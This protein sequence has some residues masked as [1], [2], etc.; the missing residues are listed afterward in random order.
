MSLRFRCWIIRL[1][2]CGLPWLVGCSAL[3]LGYNQGP[4]MAYWWLDA[5]ADFSSEQRP[6]VKSAIEAWLA[7]QRATQMPLYARELATLQTLAPKDISAAQACA[8]IVPW[9]RHAERAFDQ[10]VPA[11][12]DLVPE[13]GAEQLAH[14]EQHYAEKNAELLHS[15]LQTGT[16]ERHKATLDRTVKRAESLYGRLEDAQRRL[17]GEALRASPFDAERWFAE[18]RQRQN[19][20]LRRLRQ[21]QRERSDRP[22][23]QAGLRQLAGEMLESPRADYRAYSARVNDAYCQMAAQLHNSSTPAQR[24]KLADRLRTWEVDLRALAALR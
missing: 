23:V 4:T 16:A 13:L 10:A 24:Q 1:A 17:L 12:A 5:Y 18:R 15:H 11:L 7:W 22:M 9:Q 8:L 20:I 3:Q 6:R 14:I 2:L 19:D 21:W